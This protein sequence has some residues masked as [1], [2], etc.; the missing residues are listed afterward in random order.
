M[1]RMGSTF[2]RAVRAAFRVP[3]FI[4]IR[5]QVLGAERARRPGPFILACSHLSHLEP[6]FVSS[7]VPHH[8]RWMSRVEFYRPA[9]AATM[10]DWTGAFPVDRFGNPAPGVRTAIRLLDRGEVVGMFPEGGVALG[11]DSV[12]RGAP[13]RQGVCTISIQTQVPVIPVVVLGT[14][15]LNRFKPWL[16]TKSGRV[17]MAFGECIEPPPRAGS[18]RALRKAMAPR[19]VDAFVQT[20]QWLL[21]ESGLRDEQV[22]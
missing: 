11:K 8:V 9:W 18:R 20:Y 1:L 17:W 5:E 22:P 19:I 2:Y 6:A 16:P 21:R 7:V 12:L 14:H 15:T 3:R 13:I 10:L 4:C